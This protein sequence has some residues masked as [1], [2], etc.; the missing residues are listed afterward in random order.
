M[1]GNGVLKNQL[2]NNF[3]V[4]C[5]LMLTTDMLS[6]ANR[7]SPYPSRSC[8]LAALPGCWAVALRH[9]SRAEADDEERDLSSLDECVQVHAMI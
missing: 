1:I 9:D 2:L 4:K 5:E 7:F 6:D 3:M 8:P